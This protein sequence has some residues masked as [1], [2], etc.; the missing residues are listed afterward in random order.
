MVS[1]IMR[2]SWLV[3]CTV[4]ALT[5]AGL[6]FRRLPVFAIFAFCDVTTHPLHV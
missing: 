2:E 4:Y 3:L 1:R 6:N 5:F